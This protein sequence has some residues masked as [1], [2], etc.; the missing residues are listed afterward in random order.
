MRSAKAKAGSIVAAFLVATGG[1]S[2]VVLPGWPGGGTASAQNKAQA[3]QDLDQVVKSLHAVDTAYASANGAEA[4]ARY[5]DARAS[6]NKV[7]PMISAREAREQQ[8]LFD[9]L[10]NLLKTS[11]P[12][13]QVRNMVNG[14]LEELAEDIASELK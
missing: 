6:W 5:D 10:A 11:A 2:F 7:S 1:I 14:M 13:T 8:L 3:R 9:N 12:A 4:Q